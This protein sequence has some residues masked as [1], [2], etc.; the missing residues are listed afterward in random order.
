MAD[1]FDFRKFANR[2]LAAHINTSI[3]V[4]RIGFATSNKVMPFHLARVLVS[5][6]DQ[7]VF[8]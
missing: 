8:P 2:Q 6:A 3:N 4:R 7:A 5:F 1:D